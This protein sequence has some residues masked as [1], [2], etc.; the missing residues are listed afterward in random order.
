MPGDIAGSIGGNTPGPGP[1]TPGPGSINRWAG[2]KLCDF[3]AQPT[4][5]TAIVTSN[6]QTNVI[7]MMSP[8]GGSVSPGIR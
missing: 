5:D 8:L 4:A 6:V 1:P 3:V 7:F 2:G